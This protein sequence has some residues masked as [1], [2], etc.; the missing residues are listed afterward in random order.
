MKAAKDFRNKV[1]RFFFNNWLIVLLLS[2][3]GAARFL[4][5]DFQSPW[6]DEVHTLNE[7]APTLSVKEILNLIEV[8]EPAPPL[9]FVVTHYLVKI[10]GYST[11]VIRAFSAILGILGILAIY[12]LGTEVFNKKVG[13]LAATLLLFNH[14]HI[15]YS[16]EARMYS[17]LFLSATMSFYLFSKFV[18][19]PCLKFALLYSLG[20]TL[21]IYSQFF[22]FFVLAS[23]CVLLFFY[24]FSSNKIIRIALFKYSLIAGIIT[25]IL[26][27][28]AYRFLFAAMERSQF[29]I[30]KPTIHTM[31]EIF[32][33]FFGGSNS[34]V[35]FVILM[36]LLAFYKLFA[37]KGQIS[38]IFANLDF[39]KSSFLLLCVWFVVTV[40]IP[41]TLS[42]IR[43]PMIV[44]RYLICVL[45]VFLLSSAVGLAYLKNTLLQS[46]LVIAFIAMSAFNLIEENHYYTQV[47]KQQFREL[48]DL[49]YKPNEPIVTRFAW[50]LPFFIE[51]E[52]TKKQVINKT[53]EAYISDAQKDTVNI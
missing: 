14:F 40:A 37:S 16:Q 23:Q 32:R 38:S 33:D 1:N 50:Y 41:L 25:I 51:S 5:L 34:I 3:G 36:T 24:F 4:E 17:L 39:K 26:Y 7:V 18:K 45:P 31:I 44:N 29:W 11:F 2:I 49:G 19:D 20:V 28:P 42:Y 21:L 53:I 48:T 12:L 47:N 52:Q 6:L 46:F 15:Y 10:F 22:G 9:Y 43:L 13:I 8:T 30:Q 27:I 35:A